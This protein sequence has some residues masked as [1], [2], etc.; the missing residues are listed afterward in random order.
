VE[1]DVHVL[2]GDDALAVDLDAVVA[3]VGLR[4]APPRSSSPRAVCV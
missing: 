3:G 2:L 1:Y 4:A